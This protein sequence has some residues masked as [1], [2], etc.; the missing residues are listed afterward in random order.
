MRDW[1]ACI[2]FALYITSGVLMLLY[3]TSWH[4]ALLIPYAI[5]GVFIIAATDERKVVR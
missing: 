5:A 3:P 1:I 4:V 2:L